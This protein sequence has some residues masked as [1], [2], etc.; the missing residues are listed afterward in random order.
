MKNT[1]IYSRL[2]YSW[3]GPVLWVD[4]CVMHAVQRHLWFSEV[5]FIWDTRAA[6]LIST[7]YNHNFEW[8]VCLAR[9][10]VLVLSTSM[11]TCCSHALR[12]CFGPLFFD[13]IIYKH[14]YTVTPTATLILQYISFYHETN[15]IC[16]KMCAYF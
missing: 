13:N 4:G 5:Y 7:C 12:L 3:V 14:V 10:T 8:L 1:C 2:L 9:I 15:I 6:C 11:C 16:E